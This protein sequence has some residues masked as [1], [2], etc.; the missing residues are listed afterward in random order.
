[1]NQTNTT[2]HGRRNVLLALGAGSIGAAAVGAPALQ[3]GLTAATGSG[4]LGWWDR[5]FFSLQTG[6]ATE[7]QSVLGQVFTL[8]GEK[9]AV[10]VLL[11][12]VKLFPSKGVRPASCS[13]KQ[14]FSITFLAAPDKAPAG[15]RT[16]RLTHP[17]YPPLDIFVSAAN[18][19]PKG[20][21]LAA[22]F[23]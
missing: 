9:G 13:R 18:M 3:L 8:A 22:V 15:N 16:Y 4:D 11:S 19:L 10:P 5:M 20:A 17:K 1:M 12:E 2:D 14:A 21:R 23:N 6:S 7:W